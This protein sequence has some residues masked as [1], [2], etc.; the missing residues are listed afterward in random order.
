MHLTSGGDA[1]GPI[2]ARATQVAIRAANLWRTA[3]ELP[4]PLGAGTRYTDEG[5]EWAT[6]PRDPAA[7][8]FR[9]ATAALVE[10]ALRGPLPP[11]L[12]AQVPP[13]ARWVDLPYFVLQFPDVALVRLLRAEPIDPDWEPLLATTAHLADTYRAYR[14]LA[15]SLRD[16]AWPQAAQALTVCRTLYAAR[17]ASERFAIWEGGQG[18]A[19]GLDF[20]AG[21]ILRWYGNQ[22]PEAFQ[23]LDLDPTLTI[24]S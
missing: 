24:L 14:T 21:A 15:E 1:G 11:P 23:A 5:F 19:R 4:D 8:P 10:A 13:L 20:R 3:D 7:V 9:F 12:V 6:L 2:L 16:Q 22:H 18:N 17:P